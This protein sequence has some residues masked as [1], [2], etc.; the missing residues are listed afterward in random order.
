[1][2]ALISRFRWFT[3]TLIALTA[4]LLLT[5]A[6][7]ALAFASPGGITLLQLSSDPYTNNTSQHQTEVEPDSFAFGSTI[8]SAFQAG[9]FYNGGSSNIGW[10]TSTDSG[11][12]WTN[13][14]L[15]GTTVYATPAGSYARIS[16]PA[17]AYDAAHRT[18]IISS[19]ALSK[20]NAPAVLVSLSTNGGTTWSTPITVVS[21]AKTNF[22]KDWIACDDT[23][24]SKFYGHCYVEWDVASS[25]QLIEMSTSTN[26]GLVWSTPQTTANQADG[27]GGEPLVQP[28]GTVIVPISNPPFTQLLSFV[29]T[30]GGA[31]W[32]ST[33]V[34]AQTPFYTEEAKIRTGFQSAAMDGSGKVYVVWSGCSFESGCTANDLIM[35][36]T[37]D[38]INWSTPRLIPI[39]PVGSGVDHIIPALAV[40]LTTSGSSAHLALTYYYFPNASC[41]TNT[42]QLNVGYVSSTDGGT[43][44]SA[45]TQ[46]AGPM[47]LTWLANTTSGYMVGDYVGTSIV[48]G[49]AF[50][51][52]AVATAPVK[53]TLEEAIYTEAGGLQV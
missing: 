29:S 52:I 5:L 6:S 42:C 34:A 43:T 49:Q 50:P 18:W 30:D 14:F 10:A 37:T 25:S 8:V 47:M 51:I 46:L 13:G 53:Q 27:I 15:P 48:H 28:N 20:V 24:T 3:R 44:W 32:S 33:V 19:L 36:T 41:S 38:G 11:K 1:M 40:D 35:S 31:S 23:S 7:T 17:V 21:E 12:D 9:R 2:M 16:D 39:D 45:K 4:A 26:G 22:D